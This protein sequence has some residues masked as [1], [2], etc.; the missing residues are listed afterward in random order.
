MSSTSILRNGPLQFEYKAMIFSGPTRRIEVTF[1][2][3]QVTM[4]IVK[5]HHESEGHKIGVNYQLNYLRER[6]MVIKLNG[7]EAVK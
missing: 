4:Q 1:Q 5:Y 2:R 7:R 6:Y 3:R